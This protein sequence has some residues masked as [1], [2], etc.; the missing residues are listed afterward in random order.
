MAE[1]KTRRTT[2]SVKDFIAAVPNER[3]RKEAAVVLEMMAEVT[4]E[5]AAM[6]GPSIVGFGSREGKT[7]EWP[8]AAFSPRKAALV[9]YLAPGFADDKLLER[10]GPHS[11]GKSCLYVKR[12]SDVD[13]KA[14]RQ[15]IEKY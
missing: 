2:A 14:L 1:P 6:W 7:G 5:K 8:I 10:L 9:V 4:G 11:H 15:L 13:T 3:R 12:L